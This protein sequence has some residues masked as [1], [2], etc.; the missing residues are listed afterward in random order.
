M[1]QGLQNNGRGGI[2]TVVPE[3]ICFVTKTDALSHSATLPYKPLNNRSIKYESIDKL[4]N[5]LLLKP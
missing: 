4:P 3:G 1:Q 5:P 2:R